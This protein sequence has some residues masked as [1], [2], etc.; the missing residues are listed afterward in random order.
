MTKYQILRGG[1]RPLLRA[2]SAAAAVF[3]AAAC[4]PDKILDA[5]IRDVIDP[6]AVAGA[7]GLSAYRNSAL[8]DFQVAFSGSSTI[9]GQVN[10]SAL[11]GDEFDITDTFNTRIEIDR[12]DI[13]DDNS[14]NE[15]VFVSLARARVSAERSARQYGSLESEAQSEARATATDTL[16]FATG[17]AEAFAFAGFTYIFFA[18][19]YCEG[20]SFTEADDEGGVANAPPLSRDSVLRRSLQRF[21]SAF[22]FAARTRNVTSGTTTTPT[23]ISLTTARLARIGKARA[24]LNR[25]D[26]RTSPFLD[27]ALAQLGA[28]NVP[29]DYEYRILHSENSGRQN[30]GIFSYNTSQ[31]RWRQANRQGGNGLPYRDAY[32]NG[33]DV[34]TAHRSNGNTGF[35]RRAHWTSLKYPARNSYVV[36][37]SGV[38]ARLI[39][40]EVA[41]RKGDN[42][43]FL[44]RLNDLR[45]NTSLNRCV[46]RAVGCNQPTAALAALADP[47][48][49]TG[50]EDLLFRERAY[51]LF[52]TSHRL[53][54]MR[55]LIRQYGRQRETVYPTGPFEK[56]P[57]TRYGTDVSFP[58][59]VQE[60]NNSEFPQ[61]GNTCDNT[62]A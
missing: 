45:A 29:T 11:L 20:V 46:E 44:T 36:L 18:E 1:P 34:R 60:R 50:R 51:W 24:Y 6:S 27:S 16:N 22:V 7:A 9:E 49:A 2:V 62:I 21:D 48:T 12:R 41:L 10:Y 23:P 14:N 26:T 39:E 31:A 13:K 30:N 32:V 28:A 40:A 8:G 43:T 61:S 55:R 59:P 4:S 17:R 54:D 47:G 53:G 5:E 35:D 38:E 15:A 3:A 42:A 19:N 33:V 37:A 25:A 58:I 57:T 56:A 52:L